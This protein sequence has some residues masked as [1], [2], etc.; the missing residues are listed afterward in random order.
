MFK[1]SLI[2]GIKNIDKNKTMTYLTVFLFAFLFLIQGYTCS[3]YTVSQRRS[4]IGENE[5]FSKYKI[6][7]MNKT[8]SYLPVQR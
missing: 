8:L 6:L 7:I 4:M 3:Y 1:I 2:E 5:V